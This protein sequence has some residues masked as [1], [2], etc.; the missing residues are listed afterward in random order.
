M[1]VFTP[2]RTS[3]VSALEIAISQKSFLTV[4]KDPAMSWTG[5]WEIC[6]RENR[7]L[8]IIDGDEEMTNI[9]H[10]I[11]P[12]VRTVAVNISIRYVQ[13]V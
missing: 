7:S 2:V 11:V 3:T 13:D 12:H 1:I 5:A 10:V 8:L 6:N 9:T 4:G